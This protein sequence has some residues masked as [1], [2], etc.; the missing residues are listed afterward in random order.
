MQ[1]TA[2]PWDFKIFIL[3]LAAG[4]HSIARLGEKKVFGWV[5]R[6]IGSV[7]EIFKGGGKRR[8]EYKVLG[9]GMRI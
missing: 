5:A 7:R 6:G 2:L 3:V 9:E 1:L 8:K 4:W